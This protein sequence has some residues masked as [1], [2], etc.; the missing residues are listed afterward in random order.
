MTEQQFSQFAATVDDVD[1]GT[2]LITGVAIRYNTPVE[3]GRNLFEMVEPGA[4][5]K[6]IADPARVSVLWQH[7]SDAPIGRATQLVDSS[8]LMRFS[9]Q[10]TQHADVPEA[11]KALALLREGIIDEISVGFQWQKWTEVR[12]DDKLT[13]LHTRG[14]LRVAARPGA[15]EVRCVELVSRG[16]VRSA[17]WRLPSPQ[18]WSR[19]SSVPPVKHRPRS[20][21]ALPTPQLR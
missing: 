6:Q 7:D 2:G 17:R 19:R 13:I 14:R 3:R 8:E 16:V 5:A 20:P 1:E 9:A 12:E 4:F 21:F 10:I 15:R 11:R 18:R